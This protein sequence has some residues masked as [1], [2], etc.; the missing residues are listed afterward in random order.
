MLLKY[1][2]LQS[3]NFD[4]IREISNGKANFNFCQ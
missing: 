3:F 4:T 1:K 2:D